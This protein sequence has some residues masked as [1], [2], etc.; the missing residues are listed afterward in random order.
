[1]SSSLQSLRLFLVALVRF[2]LRKQSK[3][4]KFNSFFTSKKHLMATFNESHAPTS[5]NQVSELSIIMPNL[6]QAHQSFWLHSSVFAL[7][8]QPKNAKFLYFLPLKKRL[9]GSFSKAC[10]LTFR[11]YI[12]KTDVIILNLS[13]KLN[14]FW[15]HS[16]VFVLEKQPKN[17]DFQSF[18]TFKR[19]F[20]GYFQWKASTNF[21]KI[22]S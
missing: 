9:V 4:L 20:G 16:S 21:R 15:L 2:C 22:C 12:S 19:S 8:N 11:K 17:L 14:I 18:F 5:R 13:D 6:L 10:A 3:N 7:E 1:M